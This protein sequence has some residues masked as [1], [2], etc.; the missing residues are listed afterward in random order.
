MTCGLS[1]LGAFQKAGDS[2]S[3][4][5]IKETHFGHRAKPNERTP[6]G[7]VIL[8]HLSG[9]GDFGGADVVLQTQYG[10]LVVNEGDEKRPQTLFLLARAKPKRVETYTSLRDFQQ[11][12][13]RL[14]KGAKLHRYDRCTDTAARGLPE[15]I[16]RQIRQTC[17]QSR[18]R[19]MKFDEPILTCICG[20][21]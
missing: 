14:P 10:F 21:G 8:Y 5:A 7:Q 20:P 12:L 16:W 19:L 18:V 17:R 2:H 3:A 11:A 13:S 15:E 1:A 9:S 4:A 6:K